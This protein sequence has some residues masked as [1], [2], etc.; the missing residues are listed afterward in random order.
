MSNWG[1]AHE[2]NTISFGQGSDNTINWGVI[3]DKSFSG[4]TVLNPNGTP[5]EPTTATILTIGN[6]V[7]AINTDNVI[8]LE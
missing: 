5:P 7:L 3:Y 4:D 2:N 8:T 1:K 6:D